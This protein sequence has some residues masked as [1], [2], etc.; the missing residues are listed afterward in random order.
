MN[1]HDL[2]SQITDCNG[3]QVRLLGI[4]SSMTRAPDKQTAFPGRSHEG[5]KTSASQLFARLFRVWRSSWSEG[6]DVAA[7]ASGSAGCFAR[8]LL[9]A[10]EQKFELSAG[11]KGCQVKDAAQCNCE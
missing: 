4:V 8:W 6:T 10:L 1:I 5:F 7:L 11:I 9:S 2:P 3:S